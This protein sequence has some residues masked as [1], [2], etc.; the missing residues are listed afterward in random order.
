MILLMRVLLQIIVVYFGTS[1]SMDLQI[2]DLV[3]MHNELKSVGVYSF[4]INREYY[5]FGSLQKCLHH[6][7]GCLM[8]FGVLCLRFSL[9]WFE[10]DC[11]MRYDM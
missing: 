5:N 4:L 8:R 9:G 2:V 1:N 6:V 3:E 11:S 7:L 10:I